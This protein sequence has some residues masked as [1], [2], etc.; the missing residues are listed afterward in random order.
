MQTAIVAI[1]PIL[2]YWGADRARAS[3]KVSWG[4][5]ELHDARLVWEG[6]RD[7]SN[8]VSNGTAVAG[9]WNTERD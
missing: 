9:C 5:T 7:T 8:Q 3:K 6:Q 2:L 1:R 4:E